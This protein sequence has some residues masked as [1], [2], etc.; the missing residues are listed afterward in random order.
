MQSF[1][2]YGRA[3]KGDFTVDI[4]R[5]IEEY[6]ACQSDRIAFRSR[7]GEISYGAEV[8]DSAKI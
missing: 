8:K 1:F 5:K 7:T 6:A 3:S 2:I 4:V